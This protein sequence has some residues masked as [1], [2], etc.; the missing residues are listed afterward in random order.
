MIYKIALAYIVAI[1]II[2]IIVCCY[3]KIAAKHMTKHRTRESTLLLLSALGGSVAMLATMLI[4]RHKTKH[5]KFML[6]I[7]LIILLQA[8]A[9]IALFILL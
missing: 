3:D 7:P 5:V 2:S 6:G 4:I 1:S 9:V 8:A